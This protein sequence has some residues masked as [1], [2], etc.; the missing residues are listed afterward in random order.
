MPVPVVV[1]NSSTRASDGGGC[2]HAADSLRRLTR[3]A[4][5]SCMCTWRRAAFNCTSPTLAA[6]SKSS[7]GGGGG[8]FHVLCAR[9]C[10]PV[11]VCLPACLPACLAFHRPNVSQTHPACRDSLKGFYGPKKKGKRILVSKKGLVTT[12][13]A[14]SD[15]T[16]THTHTHS[17]SL[18]L[19][20][21][22]FLAQATLFLT[23]AMPLLSFPTQARLTLLRC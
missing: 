6:E 16:H 23:H 2:C 19:S 5:S 1:A 3:T 18:S 9:A 22:F 14:C 21:S 4:N 12:M 7:T 15:H 13:P 10:V 11:S 17:L 8:D 20:L